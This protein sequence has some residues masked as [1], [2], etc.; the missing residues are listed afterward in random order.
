MFQVLLSQILR[1]SRKFDFLL[2]NLHMTVTSLVAVVPP[3]IGKIIKDGPS[4]FEREENLLQNGVLHFVF[5]LSLVYIYLSLLFRSYKTLLML[6]WR[7]AHQS[8][9]LTGSP[10]YRILTSFVSFKGGRS[11]KWANIK[12][13]FPNKVLIIVSTKRNC[14]HVV[15]QVISDHGLKL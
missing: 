3:R 11:L 8:S 15:C 1:N 4:V 2:N 5:K 10:P 13:W 12:N 7:A 14:E 6:R 9:S